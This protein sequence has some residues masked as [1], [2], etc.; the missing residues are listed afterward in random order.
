MRVV[1]RLNEDVIE[2]W[3]SDKSRFSDEGL[4]LDLDLLSTPLI[5]PFLDTPR[6]ES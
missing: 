4:K 6:D 5:Q 2:D 3:I 1:P